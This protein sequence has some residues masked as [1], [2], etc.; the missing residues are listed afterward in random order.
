M[1]ALALTVLALAPILVLAMV[2]IAIPADMIERRF[3]CAMYDLQE[4]SAPDQL[5]MEALTNMQVDA[6]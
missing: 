1:L 2:V 5:R 6:A 3:S 4:H